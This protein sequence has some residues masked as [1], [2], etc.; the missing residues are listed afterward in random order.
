MQLFLKANNMGQYWCQGQKLTNALYNRSQCSGLS[1]TDQDSCSPRQPC[2]HTGTWWLAASCWPFYTSKKKTTLY[3]ILTSVIVII[4]S[5]DISFTIRQIGT[6]PL[7]SAPNPQC[8]FHMGFLRSVCLFQALYFKD[9]WLGYGPLPRLKIRLILFFVN[10]SSEF[11]LTSRVQGCSLKVIQVPGEVDKIK[12]HLK[13]W[14]DLPFMPF[15]GTDGATYP[16]PH[17]GTCFLF[18]VVADFPPH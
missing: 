8:F 13:T 14:I 10:Q 9:A 4:L 16:F 12:K 11:S 5:W 15:P 2:E 1:I 17:Q 3:E 7:I 18:Q 6:R